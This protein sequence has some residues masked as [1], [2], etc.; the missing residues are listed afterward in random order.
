MTRTLP[1]HHNLEDF[2]RQA[3]NLLHSLR[4]RDAAATQAYFSVDPLAGSGQPTLADAKYV[5]ARQYGFRSWLELK[6][7]VIFAA[8]KQIGSFPR[9]FVT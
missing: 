5:V 4:R 9:Y 7:C 1:T 3:R 8:R 2:E 6:Q